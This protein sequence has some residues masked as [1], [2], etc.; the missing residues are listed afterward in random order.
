MQAGEHAAV[1]HL[2][3]KQSDISLTPVGGDQKLLKENKYWTSDTRL[4]VNANIAACPAGFCCPLS[5]IV[6]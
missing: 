4:Q 3:A 6:L 2:A 1:E 5:D